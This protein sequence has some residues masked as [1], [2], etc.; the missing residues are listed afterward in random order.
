M[1]RNGNARKVAFCAMLSAL[2]VAILAVGSVIGVLDL[3]LSL[4]A[5]AVVLLADLEFS[6]GYGWSVFAVSGVL[7][8]LLPVK[9]PA[10]LFVLFFGWYPLFRKAI[11]RVKKPVRILIKV[12]LF[13]VLTAIYLFVSMHF[14]GAAEQPFWM[15]LLI[16]LS[17]NLMFGLYEPALDRV[18]R[19]YEDRLRGKLFFR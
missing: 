19:F 15:T 14:L 6:A 4:I 12:T 1:R 7:S 11:F 16:A 18:I 3:S 13:E 2:V 5:G 17:A 10:F 8:F 9:T